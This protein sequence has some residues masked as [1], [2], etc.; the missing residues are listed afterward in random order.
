MH[1]SR[2]QTVAAGLGF[3]SIGLGVINFSSVGLSLKLVPFA[4]LGA[5]AGRTLIARMNQKAFEWAALLLTLAAG[6]RM[7]LG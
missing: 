1:Q 3:F 4:I 7:L 2:A 6:V 5:L